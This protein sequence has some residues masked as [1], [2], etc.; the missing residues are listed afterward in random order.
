MNPPALR[1]SVVLDRLDSIFLKASSTADMLEKELFLSYLIVK[2]HDQWNFRSRQIILRSFGRSEG[3]MMKQLRNIWGRRAMDIGWE[4]DWHIPNNA[5]RAGRL[6]NVPDLVQIQNALG[7]VTYIDDIRW[8]RNAI[9]HN[10]PTSFKKYKAMT[11]SKYRIN[12]I[13]PCF[14]PMELNPSTGN[15]IY[16]DWCLE[17]KTALR[18]A[19]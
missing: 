10:I 8:A 3:I 18:F 4:P 19:L 14:L 7:A 17:L 11:L 6:L 5:I 9:V 15:T 2:L 16:E 13:S 12:N 1:F